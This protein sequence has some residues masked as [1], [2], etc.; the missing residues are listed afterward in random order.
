[1]RWLSYHELADELVPY[2]REMGYTHIELLPITEHPFDG[3]WGYQSVGYFAP[4]SRFGSPDGFQDAAKKS[5]RWRR[6][7]HTLKGR[8]NA[9]DMDRVGLR[10]QLR[11][12]Q[13]KALISSC[14]TPMRARR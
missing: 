9:A 3:S 1:M 14:S 7:R 12:A 6:P 10:L 2:V 13:A 11:K 4:T 8:Q 5:F